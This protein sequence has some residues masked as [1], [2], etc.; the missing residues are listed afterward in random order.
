MELEIPPGL[1][2]EI[3]TLIEPVKNRVWATGRPEN[4][5]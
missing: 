3:Q 2:S 5:G 1:L 4:S